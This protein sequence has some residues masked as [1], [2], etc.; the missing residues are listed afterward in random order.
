MKE[1]LGL[2]RFLC[3]GFLA[4]AGAVWKRSR[5]PRSVGRAR[6]RSVEKSH[7]RKGKIPGRLFFSERRNEFQAS[8]WDLFWNFMTFYASVSRFGRKEGEEGGEKGN[9]LLRKFGGGHF[10]CS[11]P[12][13]TSGGGLS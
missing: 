6:H 11:S 4:L 9:R 2:G 3:E 13:T 12:T 1:V 10:L 8:V 5:R 7:G